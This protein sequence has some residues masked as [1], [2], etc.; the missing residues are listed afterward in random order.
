MYCIVY[1]LWG[2]ITGF[3][4]IVWFRYDM[5][6]FLKAEIEECIGPLV[7]EEIGQYTESGHEHVS[8]TD[9]LVNKITG[10]VTQSQQ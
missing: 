6:K 8:D 9:T 7:D 1:I 5:V 10:K 4:L 2:R 3:C